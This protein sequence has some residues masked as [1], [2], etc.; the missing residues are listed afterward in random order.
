MSGM[1]RTAERRYEGP[2]ADTLERLTAALADRYRI[3]RER[4]QGGMVPALQSG[5]PIQMGAPR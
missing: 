2:M 5:T 4:G 3:E 1:T